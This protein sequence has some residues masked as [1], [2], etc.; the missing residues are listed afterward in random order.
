M[1]DIWDNFSERDSLFDRLMHKL[2][3]DHNN[4]C[5][6]WLGRERHGYGE[7]KYKGRYIGTHRAAYLLFIGV[8]PDN[9]CVLHKCDV[10]NC[11]NPK[12]LFL[13]TKK[14]NSLDAIS[15]NR[16]LRGEQIHNHRLTA[17]D[18]IYIRQSTLSTRQLAK[19]LNVHNVTVWAAKTGKT[20]KHVD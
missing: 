20:W 12:H 11:C 16:I 3:Y 5:W 9:L 6:L 19:K 2:I 13:G 15:K 18:V 10:P 4:G 14:D 7:I 17:K 1:K 8:I